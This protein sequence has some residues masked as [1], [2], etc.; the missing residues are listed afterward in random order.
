MKN[1]LPDI[2]F[3]IDRRGRVLVENFSQDCLLL[4]EALGSKPPVLVQSPYP[5][6]HPA[7]SP[8]GRGGE[9]DS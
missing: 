3:H 4:A 1:I 6:P 9:K 8:W 7:L 5:P 2:R